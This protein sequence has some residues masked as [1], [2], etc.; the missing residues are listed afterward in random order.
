ML[1]HFDIFRCNR[2]LNESALL[3]TLQKYVLWD[4]CVKGQMYRDK[5]CEIGYVHIIIY[6]FKCNEAIC[7]W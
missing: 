7:M 6:F 2:E 1:I 5:G 4:K 3:N